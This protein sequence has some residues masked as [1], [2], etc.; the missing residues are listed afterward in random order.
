MAFAD[1]VV[2]YIFLKE[3][4][5]VLVHI[6]MK[7]VHNNLVDYKSALALDAMPN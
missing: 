7:F 5:C 1:G 6:S 3:K 4:L 2:S